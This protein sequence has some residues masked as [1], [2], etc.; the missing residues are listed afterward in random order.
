MPRT[1]LVVLLCALLLTA[2]G[3]SNR[4]GYNF[5]DWYMS[6][7]VRQ[8]I[9]LDRPQRNLVRTEIRQFHQWHR[10]TQ[11]PQYANFLEQGLE[12][13]D[14]VDEVRPEHIRALS[15]QATPL[16]QN[17]LDYA[18]EPAAKLFETLSDRQVN[19]LLDN[20]RE[21]QAEW[22]KPKRNDRTPEERMRE[23]VGEWFGEVTEEQTAYIETWSENLKP[24]VDQRETLH[25]RWLAELEQV[26]ARRD[27]REALEKGLHRLLIDTD[28]VYEALDEQPEEKESDVYNQDIALILLAQ[29]LNSRT[30][31]QDRH[32]RDKVTG[33]INDFRD[34]AER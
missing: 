12:R 14:T 7:Q 10:E 19:Q 13:L 5:L 15:D 30:E 34:W 6:W 27:D 18:R 23:Q 29:L 3:C 16:W 11:L 22:R 4:I 24:T 32:F 20:V 26:L 1:L 17:L 28:W 21:Q 8:Y 31:A 9:R 33:Y 25:G 2:S